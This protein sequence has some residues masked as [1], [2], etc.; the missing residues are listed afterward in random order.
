MQMGLIE[1]HISNRSLVWT[2]VYL[3]ILVACE[4]G[5][6]PHPLTRLP[7]LRS[8]SSDR[9]RKS[10]GAGLKPGLCLR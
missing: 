4:S 10:A 6:G 3:S 7:I 8:G 5:L 9:E 2:L 1:I